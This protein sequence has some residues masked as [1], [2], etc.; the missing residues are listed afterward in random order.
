[1]AGRIHWALTGAVAALVATMLLTVLRL[2]AGIPL[3]VE[4]ASDRVLPLVPVDRFLQLLGAFGG[5]IAA[6]EVAFGS[7]FALQV[8]LG[9][10]VGFAV[11]SRRGPRPAVLAG[12]LGV[13]WI[14]LLAAFWP[15]LVSGYTGRGGA[16]AVA[17]NAVALALAVAVYG[18]LLLSLRP[19]DAG[20]GAG[21]DA[22]RRG[23]LIAGAGTALAIATGAGAIELFRRGAFTYDGSVLRG[24]V[25]P[26]TPNDHFYVVTKNLI[27]PYVAEGDWRLRLTGV[28]GQERTWTL[29]Q[30]RGLPATRQA[31][32]LECI[33]N[34]V[35]YGLLSNAVWTGVP[36]RDLIAQGS[37]GARARFVAL[38]GADGYTYGLPLESA[39]RPEVIVAHQMNGDPLPQRHGYPARAVVPGRYGEGSAKWLTEIE[40]L[41]SPLTGYYESQGWRSGFVQTMS[42]IDLPRSGARLALAE[43]PI[44]VRG[45]A[46][47]GDRGVGG[48]EVSDDGTTW[49]AAALTHAGT[50]LTWALW[51]FEWT[52]AGP[53]PHLLQA[54]ATDGAG[55]PQQEGA[56]GFVPAGATGYHT[57]WVTI[58]P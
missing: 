51:S 6:K 55:N 17:V 34:G 7:S 53:G 45:V 41:D 56:H 42:R 26:I 13:T 11:G 30:L 40:I 32:T 29:A 54:R 48:V 38:R 27:D 35:G 18:L 3:P 1:M 8:A 2:V 33:S 16:L 58:D 20:A 19:R 31:A 36:M 22:G 50:P 52:P 12:A 28:V 25:D 10:A 24:P 43:A 49:R 46:F 23:V 9:A 57:R 14:A 39:T 37:A 5:P 21:I 4:T 44:T 47:A 15:A